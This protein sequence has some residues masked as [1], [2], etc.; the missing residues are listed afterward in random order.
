MSISATSSSVQYCRRFHPTSSS[1][2][3]QRGSST[4][5]PS[6]RTSWQPT[7][8]S[9]AVGP[10]SAEFESRGLP[11][12]FRF[13]AYVDNLLRALAESSQDLPQGCYK[14]EALASPLQSRRRYIEQPRGRFCK[15]PRACVCLLISEIAQIQVR[16]YPRKFAEN[17]ICCFQ[18][19]WRCLNKTHSFTCASRVQ[20]AARA[21]HS[22]CLV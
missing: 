16:H 4:A 10:V 7:L 14:G 3:S 2:R 20:I 15:S 12:I 9:W 11:V 21:L 6:T 19:V 5:S 17:G 18:A 1:Q 13:V 8:P 22:H